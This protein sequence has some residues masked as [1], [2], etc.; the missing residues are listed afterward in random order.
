M[1][2]SDRLPSRLSEIR[3]RLADAS[4]QPWTLPPPG[5][6]RVDTGAL[7]VAAAG[8][9][10]VLVSDVVAA[11]PDSYLEGKLE[12]EF[13]CDADFEHYCDC[14]KC[15][16]AFEATVHCNKTHKIEE[17]YTHALELPSDARPD[18]GETVP[19]PAA[20]GGDLPVF[21]NAGDRELVRWAAA[22]LEYLLALLNNAARIFIGTVE[23]MPVYVDRVEGGWRLM[24]GAQTV[25][26]CAELG[27]AID[28][29]VRFTQAGGGLVL[30]P[31]RQIVG[32]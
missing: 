3:T 17:K 24:S 30:V 5:Y 31:T 20:S 12:I 28:R 25:G 2:P 29:A 8:D 21:V 6:V 9:L 15:G 7:I 27:E 23:R 13:T 16:H 26:D 18:Q 19:I 14:P 10:D 1:P 22:D 4:P 32:G 11:V